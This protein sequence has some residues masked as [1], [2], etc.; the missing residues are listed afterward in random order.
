MQVGYGSQSTRPH[1]RQSKW[2]GDSTGL[3]CWR[4]AQAGGGRVPGLVGGESRGQDMAA[5][6]RGK[7]SE[8]QEVVAE[9]RASLEVIQV[10]GG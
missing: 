4:A 7:Q 8:H 1:W 6:P 3:R 9:Y 10:A 5:R 2:Q